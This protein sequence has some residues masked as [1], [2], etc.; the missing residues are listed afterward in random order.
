MVAGDVIEA[1]LDNGSSFD[2]PALILTTDCLD[3]S[4]SCVVGSEDTNTASVIYRS[5]SDQTVYLIADND[6]SGTTDTFTL[7]VDVTAS[8]CDPAIFTNTCANSTDV[9]F[10]DQFGRL[11]TYTCSDMCS[12]GTC[13]NPDADACF[14]RVDI[15]AD[16]KMAGGTTITGTWGNFDSDFEGN[17][18]Q[19]CSAISS[20]LS[21]GHDA[22]YEVTLAAGETVNATLEL[23]NVSGIWYADPAI[24]IVPANACGTYGTCYDGDT[25]NDAPASASYTA[26]SAETVLILADSDDDN[27]S[28]QSE[29]FQLSVDIQ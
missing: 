29:E 17:G 8:Q 21:D 6:D 24:A 13:T 27:S 18:G 26:T 25:G 11:Q 14:E 9:E 1:T 5:P 23:I 12:S 15:T 16:A 4:N 2:D 7:D 19:N 3:A 28:T 22:V 10:C 20:G